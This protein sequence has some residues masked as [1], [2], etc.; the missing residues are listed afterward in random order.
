MKKNTL[1]LNLALVAIVFLTVIGC[2]KKEELVNSVTTPSY[3]CTSCITAPE[4]KSAYDNSS[5]GMYKGVVIGSSGTIKFDIGNTDTS[6]IKAYMVIDGVSVTLTANVK[7]VAGS[8]Y[9]SPFTGTLNGETVS[10]TFSVDATGANPT[11]T[12]M[13]I[14]GHPNATLAIAKETSTSLIKVFEGTAKNTTTSKNATFNLM[15]STSLKRWYARVREDGSTGSSSVEG[16]FDNNILSFD[17]GKGAT[18][19]ATL[20]GDNIINGTWKNSK[21]EAGTWEAKRTL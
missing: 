13:N 17:D 8:S 10:I 3:S 12:S 21:P 20:S 6:T 9:V 4:A 7:W 11:V 15:L 18:G 19:S 2:K 16:T 5:R 14:P 1:I